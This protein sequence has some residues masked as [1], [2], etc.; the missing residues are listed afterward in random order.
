VYTAQVSHFSF[1]NCDAPFPVVEIYGK[2]VDEDGNPL[3]FYQICIQAFNDTRTGYGWSG[4]DG[5]FRGKVPKGELL[6]FQVKDDCGN[7]IFE[8]QIGPFQTEVSLGEV[9]VSSPDMINIS[10][11]LLDCDGNPVDN[12]YAKITLE[13]VSN[14][15]IAPTDEEGNFELQI[16]RCQPLGNFTVQGW[17]LDD[18]SYSEILEITNAERDIKIGDLVLCDELEEYID[19][20]LPNG[21]IVVNP[22]VDAEIL[23]GVLIITTGN[24]S[25]G[26]PFALTV[27][28]NNAAL[29]SNTD[30]G[31]FNFVMESSNNYYW[32]TC[33]QNTTGGGWNNCTDINFEITSLG[34]V[35]DYIEGTYM[36]EVNSPNST[37]P[38]VVMGSF[39]VILDQD[40]DLGTISGQAWN[41]QDGDGIWGVNDFES[42]IRSVSLLDANQNVL[43]TLYN[44]SSYEFAALEQG[45]YFLSVVPFSGLDFTLQDQG[46]DDTVDSDFDPNT[47][48]TD[49]ISLGDNEDLENVDVGLGYAGFLECW[50]QDIFQDDCD[51]GT[52]GFLIN[53]EGSQGPFEIR[54]MVNGNIFFEDNFQTNEYIYSGLPSG[55]YEVLISDAQGNECQNSVV[56]EQVE[57][58]CWIDFVSP[59]C[60]RPEGSLYVNAAGGGFPYTYLWSTGATTTRINNL[61]PGTYTVLVTDPFG[62]T[63]E[64]EFE[65]EGLG[66]PD[67]IVGMVFSDSLATNDNVYGPGD[68]RVPGIFVNLYE[69]SDLNTV[70][71]E[72]RTTGNGNYIF[73]NL[74]PGDYV[75]EFTSPNEALDFVDKDFGTDD[76]IDSDVNP[77]TGRSD[78]ITTGSGC[79]AVDAGIK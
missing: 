33:G 66:G 30:I 40:R 2:L 31:Y 17:N 64:C 21:D 58:E 55:F 77:D 19:V 4:I 76:D 67:Q 11:R 25:L 34:I 78:V 28:I 1:W 16:I 27:H 65:L 37:M 68:W 22:I 14:Y 49:L 57:I 15:Y 74:V 62:C 54:I 39:R 70:I 3:P 60:D 20:K 69:A 7:I 43:Q 59:I 36:G 42:E 73:E 44:V 9:V 38:D 48:L 29:G 12:G 53:I 13:G 51:Q 10:G 18:Y 5:S 79:I 61:V 8:Q 23:D 35:G 50:I 75:V 6:T 47:G 26:D 46:G 56:I 52:G 45:D 24:D 41:D 32:Y 72:T 63:T 71:A